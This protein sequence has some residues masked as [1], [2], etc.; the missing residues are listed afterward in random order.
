MMLYQLDEISAE[1][2]TYLYIYICLLNF[3][4]L[5]MPLFFFFTF[6]FAMFRYLQKIILYFIFI[7]QITNPFNLIIQ[8]LTFP[9]LYLYM[10]F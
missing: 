5:G 2:F 7:L 9:L 1:L 6:S 8:N 4:W 10:R 3:C